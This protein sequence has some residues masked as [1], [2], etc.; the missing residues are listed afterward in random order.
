MEFKITEK[1]IGEVSFN[2]EECKAY[3]Q[4]QLKQYDNLVVVEEEL[5]KFKE[6][7]AKLNKVAKAMNDRKIEIKKEYM[8]PYT[9]FENKVKELIGMVDDVNY[10][11]DT[12]LIGFEEKRKAEKKAEIIAEYDKKNAP[13]PIEKIWSDKWLNKTYSMKNVLEEVDTLLKKI[14]NEFKV[15]EII[16]NGNEE[17]LSILKA[18]FVKT[19]DVNETVAEYEQEMS[20]MTKKEEVKV[21]NDNIV[22]EPKNEQTF[23]LSF[24]IEG[25]KEQI[26]ALSMFL[27]TNN[28]TYRRLG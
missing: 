25:T 11:I 2:Y 27:K 24:E 28:Y 17:K 5:P 19:L 10:K 26:Q 18:K 6:I 22:E 15:L 21:E 12:Q 20:Y 7:K 9:D 23:K 1:K 16:C 13:I 8:Q 4:E 14:N 3:L